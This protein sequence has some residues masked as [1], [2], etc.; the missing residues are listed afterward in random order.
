MR[1]SHA[2][3]GASALTIP[4]WFLVALGWTLGA[5]ALTSIVLWGLVW[6]RVE[7][8]SAVIPTLRR[9]E[10]LARETPPRSSV[11]VVVPAHNESRVI[12]GL[13]QSLRQE[14]YPNL[15]VVLCLDRCT[16]NTAAL[17][18]QA[19]GDDARFEVIEITACPPDWAGKVH[20]V[21]TGA[22]TSR[23]AADAE[24]LLFAD[25]DTLF[26][27]GCI[28]ASLA[29]MRDRRVEFLSLLSTLTYHTWFE[30]LV[31][32]AAGF[33]LL[34]QYPL[35]RANAREER[36]AF[37]NG[38]FMLLDRATYEKVGGHVA[39]K[40]AV[41]ED[42]ALAK[43]ADERGVSIGVFLADGLFYCR[44]YADW[45]QFRRG[46]KRI[47][48]EAA[49]RK[50]ARL[51][52]SSMRLRW[53][54]TIVPLWMLPAGPFGLLVLGRDPAM[55]WTLLAMWVLGLTLWLGSLLRISAISR[56]PLWTAPLHLIGAWL[57]ANILREAQQDLLRGATTTWGGREFVMN[58]RQ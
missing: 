24:Y 1:A 29:M 52:G 51:G 37:A 2:T 19:I 42:L 57:T 34:R 41:L 25:A 23:G 5:G 49:N 6:I 10:R 16:D 15:R 43:R 30:R 45:Q 4:H 53:L 58:E 8:S 28:A 39:V 35:T 55:G 3:I 46:W 9:G 18:R 33:E 36:R 20:A 31:Q 27:P 54:G 26:E 17:A 47:Y 48:T 11:C 12:A 13:V 40:N 50:A 44:M 56:A 21:H 32:T 14:T 7:H 22:T 38:Q